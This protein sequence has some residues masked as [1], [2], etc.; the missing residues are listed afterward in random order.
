MSRDAAVRR[1]PALWWELLRVCWRQERRVTVLVLACMSIGTVAFAGVGLAAKTVVDAAARDDVTVLV[2]AAIA[3]ATAYVCDWLIN[4]ICFTM[5]MHVVERVGQLEI[6]PGIMRACSQIEEIDHLEQPE[7]LDRITAVRGQAWAIVDS[8]WAV[9]ESAALVLRLALTFALLG[10]VSPWLLLLL[11]CTAVQLALENLGHRGARQAEIAAAE[12]G[13]VQRHLFEVAVGA[14]TS[15]EVRVAGAAGELVRL[16]HAAAD[17]V[18]RARGRASFRGAAFSTVGWAVFAVGFTAALALVVREAGLPGG[19]LGNVVLTITVGSQVRSVL[20]MAVNRSSDAG[21]YGRVLEPYLWLRAYAADRL[22]STG[23]GLSPPAELREGI[24]L[25]GVRFSYPGASTPAVDGVSV[26]IPAG[27]VVAVVGEYGSGK[28]TLVKLLAKLYRPTE[29]RITADGIDLADLDTTAWRA[30][31]SAAYQDFGR[32]RTTFAT[33]VGLG[34][35]PRMDDAVAIDDAVRAADADSVRSRLPR[36]DRTEL[37]NGFGGVDLSEGQWQ[38]VALARACM[39]VGPLLFVLDEPTASL[40]APSEHAIFARY[41]ARS[42]R[43][44]DEGGAI[45]VIVSH[46]FSTVAGADLILV[47]DRGRLVESGSHA[48]LVGR[49]GGTYSTLYGIQA[50]AYATRLPTAPAPTA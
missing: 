19:S 4:D 9:V 12:D 39:R 26:R 11:P 28:T 25:H 16:Q 17:R 2:V 7:F 33:G 38:K 13:R 31:M 48:D 47:M 30:R 36:G 14:A 34:D 22:A 45:T 10:D 15:K 3:A 8:A 40:D 20:Q 37:G 23:P 6:E 21:G 44:A 35:P 27:S 49:Q 41:A 18:V 50:D 1:Y 29:G 24:E 46:R 5:R 42:R 43:I 32:Y